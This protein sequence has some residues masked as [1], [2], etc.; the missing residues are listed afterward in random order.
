MQCNY[1]HFAYNKC[2]AVKYTSYICSHLICN[3]TLQPSCVRNSCM[4]TFFPL[5]L[6][7]VKQM[8]TDEEAFTDDIAY[9]EL[10][11]DADS[12]GFPSSSS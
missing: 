5:S 6:F 11:A 12:S 1:G 10:H 7:Q 4:P 3:L 9:M 2:I 8:R